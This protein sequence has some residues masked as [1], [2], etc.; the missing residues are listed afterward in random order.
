MDRYG[1]FKDP[2][3]SLRRASRE[4]VPAILMMNGERLANFSVDK[5]YNV[6]Y[7]NITYTK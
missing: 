4:T 1:V 7:T 3:D 5:C 2:L 6:W